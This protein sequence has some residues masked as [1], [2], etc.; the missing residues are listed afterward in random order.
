MSGGKLPSAVGH[1]W[2]STKRNPS[3]IRFFESRAKTPLEWVE[4]F[5]KQSPG[6]GAYQ[7]KD[8][9]STGGKFSTARPIGYIDRCIHK[10]KREP[11]PFEYPQAGMGE[12]HLGGEFS[13]SY[14]KTFIEQ[15][16]YRSSQ[17]PGP[18]YQ[19]SQKRRSYSLTHPHISLLNVC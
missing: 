1:Q 9:V 6:P 8:R 4:Y 16:I 17:I 14:P 15:E 3:R 12:H 5:A 7:T 18:K 11:G 13:T 2:E 10:G 19:V